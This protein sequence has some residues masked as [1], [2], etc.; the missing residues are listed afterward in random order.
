MFGR[1]AAMSRWKKANGW[2]GARIARGEL[3]LQFSNASERCGGETAADG[4]N[5]MLT[6]QDTTR[7]PPPHL[8]FQRS[9]LK[10]DDF[11]CN[12]G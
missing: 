7:P 5:P 10:D 2:I 4:G 1:R 11:V 6:R 3:V 8:H 9:L 12:Q